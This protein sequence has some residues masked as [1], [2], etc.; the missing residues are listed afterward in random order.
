MKGVMMVFVTA[1]ISQCINVIDN[2]IVE[3]TL[4]L[5]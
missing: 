4:A 1:K 3:N 5:K 2:V